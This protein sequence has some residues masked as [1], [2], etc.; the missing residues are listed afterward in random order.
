MT[1]IEELT[2]IQGKIYDAAKHLELAFTTREK[3]ARDVVTTND[4]AVEQVLVDA[5]IDRYPE[6]V[7]I[8]EETH[9]DMVKGHRAWVIDPIDGTT[10]YARGIP[11]YGIQLA[12]LVDEV[13]R[14]SLIY[15]VMTD[16]LY[17]AVRG[18]GAY[19]NGA[20]IHVGSNTT[21]DKAIV[22]LG[23]FSTTNDLRNRRMLKAMGQLMGQVYKLRIHSTA[24]IDLLFLASG[25]TDVHIMSANHPWDYLPGLLL[26]HEAGGQVDERL[27]NTL[28]EKRTLMVVAST[29][30]LY[31]AV[32][33]YI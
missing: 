3:A 8:S 18:E 21:L 7:I 22:T 29:A 9:Q 1:R 17:V 30:A 5:I 19:C 28:G 26:V 11:M 14:F 4:L 27:L 33:P 24:A 20:P 32:E 25:K 2:F 10:N 16:E 31:E 13:T 12:F 15:Y 23:D 6:D